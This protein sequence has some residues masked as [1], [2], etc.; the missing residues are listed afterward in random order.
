MEVVQAIMRRRRDALAKA[1]AA[2]RH[3][4]LVVGPEGRKL[5]PHRPQRLADPGHVAVPKNG[6]DPAKRGSPVSL[7]C[8]AMK[9]VSACAMVSRTV[10]M[11]SA[12]ATRPG[13]NLAAGMIAVSFPGK[14]DQTPPEVTAKR[15][16]DL[17]RGK[18]REQRVGQGLRI[19]LLGAGRIGRIHAGNIAAHARARLVAVADAEPA[20]A[21]RLATATTAVRDVDAVIAAG[22]VDAVVICTPTNTHAE[23]IERA[24]R[25]GK[26]IFCEKPVSLDAERTRACLEVV[27]AFGT[28]LMVGFNRRF[29]PSFSAVK[30]RIVTGDI[31]AVELVTILSRDPSPPPIDYVARSGGLFRDMM[32]HDFD[33]ARFLLGEEPVE[34]QATASCLVDP[35]IAAVG[36]VDTA[37]VLLRTAGGRIAQISNSR[38]ATYGYDQRVEVHGSLGLLCAGNR[39]STTVAFADAR[40]YSTDPA[41]PFFLERYAEAYRAEMDAFIAGV[42][43][44]RPLSPSGED[45]LKA[46]LL[47]DA[48]TR[49]ARDGRS[50]SLA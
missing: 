38:R 36:D 39:R 48:A 25:A 21:A 24:A 20:A 22:D 1:I 11:R 15:P 49:A 19:G 13:S 44:G 12:S 40:G 18:P 6:P 32:I 8:A 41:L 23:L 33:M 29:D 28:P 50:V 7:R 35:R 9:R 42:L 45:G 3:A 16:L 2:W 14:L 4:L 37:A 17:V 10:L 34:V 47:A 5:V 27:R 46:Q 43:E 31:G 30:Q 26:A